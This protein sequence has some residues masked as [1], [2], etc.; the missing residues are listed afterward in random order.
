MGEKLGIASIR[1]FK[2]EVIY[3]NKSFK[4]LFKQFCQAQKLLLLLV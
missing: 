4:N 3:K 1:E 2:D